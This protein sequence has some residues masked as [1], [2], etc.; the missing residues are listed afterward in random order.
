ML[1]ATA[2]GCPLS[3]QVGEDEEAR[4]STA[5]PVCMPGPR[6]RWLCEPSTLESLC[7]EFRGQKVLGAQVKDTPGLRFHAS[8]SYVVLPA[9]FFLAMCTTYEPVFSLRIIPISQFTA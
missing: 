6:H 5:S 8:V 2:R 9:P 4:G 1:D 3:Q 7:H